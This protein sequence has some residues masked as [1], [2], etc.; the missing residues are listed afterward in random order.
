VK[1]ALSS[2]CLCCFTFEKLM[3]AWDSFFRNMIVTQNVMLEGYP[4]PSHAPKLRVPNWCQG[5][6]CSGV[7][8]RYS[9]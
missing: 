6:P 5:S 4:Q 9:I 3:K 2:G 1:M 8:V 7:E